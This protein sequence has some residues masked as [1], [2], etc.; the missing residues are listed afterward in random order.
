[1]RTDARKELAPI[2][3]NVSAN[4]G[5]LCRVDSAFLSYLGCGLFLF[6]VAKLSSA[7]GGPAALLE[8]VD[9]ITGISN[10]SLFAWTGLV[11]LCIALLALFGKKPHL[12]VLSLAALFGGISAYRL[13]RWI[14][15]AAVEPCRCLG[16]AFDRLGISPEVQDRFATG[17]L[18]SGVILSYYLLM[19]HRF[20]KQA[21]V[22]GSPTHSHGMHAFT[23]SSCLCWFLGILTSYLTPPALAEVRSFE[24]EMIRVQFDSQSAPRSTNRYTFRG[25]R[26]TERFLFF[27]GPTE[28][29]FQ[30]E[31]H[32]GWDGT[33]S[34]YFEVLTVDGFRYG[35]DNAVGT[36]REV[37]PYLDAVPIP[38]LATRQAQ[39]L[40]LALSSPNALKRTQSEGHNF[41]LLDQRNKEIPERESAV[42]FQ[43][44][45]LNGEIRKIECN[46]PNFLWEERSGRK[47]RFLLP[48][49]FERGFLRWEFESQSRDAKT[50]FT[51]RFE[52]RNYSYN[53]DA[54]ADPSRPKIEPLNLI[55]GEIRFGDVVSEPAMWRPQLPKAHMRVMDLRVP[56]EIRD[57]P[58]AVGIIGHV[59]TSSDKEWNIQFADIER[60]HANLAQAIKSGAFREAVLPRRLFWVGLFLALLVPLILFRRT[61]AKKSGR[62][63][64][65]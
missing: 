40:A 15:G 62:D 43:R 33:N 55:S 16:S 30:L 49:P 17:F 59:W 25:L 14:E 4:P 8:N 9:P 2:G 24:G 26:D 35:Q 28:D 64:T 5:K 21:V 53:A 58:E 45:D 52:F 6:G 38:A 50:K 56:R 23:R 12:S 20:A 31:T 1:M 42:T 60:R 44:D 65:R 37:R 22:A 54:V 41:L 18:L 3:R 36:N 51:T 19:K 57:L 13:S 34:Y 61:K 27:T 7:F 11:E 32:C 48:P 46:S 63:S 47:R 39:V 29:D 10:R